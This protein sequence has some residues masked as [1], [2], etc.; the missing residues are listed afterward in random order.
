VSDFQGRGVL[1]VGAGGI[2]AQVSHQVAAAEGRV[3]FTYNR[4]SVAAD[5]LA[6]SIPEEALAGY[7]QLDVTD[8]EATARV[9]NEARD[10]MGGVDA[11][12]TTVGYLHHLTTF[13]EVQ[14]STVRLTVE[15]E[16]FGVF[17]LA[18]SVLP[19]MR[20]AGYGRIVTVGSDSGKVGSSAEAASAAARGGVIAF[21]KA[22]ARETARSDICVNV[23]CPGPTET[24]LL[25][26]M[27]ADRGLSGKLMNAMVRAIPKRRAGTAA[28]VAAMAVFLASEQASYV[29]GQAISVS[30]GLTMC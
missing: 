11:L 12:V 3:F 21:S 27:L 15:I 19:I 26:S 14:M 5:K 8:A 7:A 1:V 2:G 28:E 4:N 22:L 20:D 17:N 23:V 25:E 18:K 29:T 9:V 30:G 10:A 6:A 13:D 16:L 24:D